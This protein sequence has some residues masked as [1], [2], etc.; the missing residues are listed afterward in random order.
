[1]FKRVISFVICFVIFLTTVLISFSESADRFSD[2]KKDA[3]YYV[4]VNFVYENGYMQGISDNEFGINN[5]MTRAM[6]AV[7]AARI[8]DA[9]VDPNRND[10]FTDVPADSWYTG[11]VNWAFENGIV[12]GYENGEFRP[13]QKITREQ[14]AVL[15]RALGDYLDYDVTYEDPTLLQLYHDRNQISPYALSS[16]CW[17]LDYGLI[18]GNDDCALMPKKTATRAETAAIIYRFSLYRDTPPA[19]P[20]KI[21][22]VTFADYDGKVLYTDNVA[23]GK[24]ARYRA[25]D[26][27]KAADK[28]YRYS[29][30]GWDKPLGPIES[31]TVFI[32]QYSSERISYKVTFLNWDGAELYNAYVLSGENAVYKG[33]TPE[34]PEDEKNMYTFIGWDKSMNAIYCDTVFT[35]RFKAEPKPV[36]SRVIDPTKPMI[37][38]TFD[39]GPGSGSGPILDTLEQYNCV[40]TFFDVGTNVERNPSI[41]RREVEVGCEIGNHSYNH[42][43]FRNLS[44]NQIKEQI[45]KTNNAFINILGYAPELMRPPYGATND[46]I[47]SIINMKIILWSIDT[48]DWKSRNADS[49]YKIA[50]GEAYDGA[51]ILM[52][53]LYPS[54]AA[55]VKRIVPALISRGY[56]LVTVSELAYYKGY[57]MI[58]GQ[59]YFHFKNK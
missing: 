40:A 18:A 2:V 53:S 21:F 24:Y 10:H 13:S 28:D 50:V 14:A 27:K 29:F 52:H 51:I 54:T 6:F 26:P 17:A 34:K 57:Q 46:N 56:Q 37:A 19:V 25:E 23:E 7:V 35:A 41:I 31:D 33:K 59:R 30:I 3:W 43:N 4:P 45:N 16:I 47:N 12:A 48:L 15:L 20:P 1:M 11:A 32:A 49:V 5:A 58:N 39:D 9:D 22:K 36:S 44:A 38:I 42:P 8:A 55:A